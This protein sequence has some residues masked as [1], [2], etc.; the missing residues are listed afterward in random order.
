MGRRGVRVVSAK[1]V[2]PNPF[3]A[4]EAIVVVAQLRQVL[5]VGSR[6][7]I[8]EFRSGSTQLRQIQFRHHSTEL[9]GPY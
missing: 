2:S 9:S 3:H 8:S 7:P 6:W 1:A 4:V 5:I